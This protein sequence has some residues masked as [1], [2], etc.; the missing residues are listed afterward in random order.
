MA[1]GDRQCGWY[2]CDIVIYVRRAAGY[3]WV[4]AGR[5]GERCARR[6]AGWRI[7]AGRRVAVYEAAVAGS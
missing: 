3:D 6:Q 7:K 2:E 1:T 5:T 4:A